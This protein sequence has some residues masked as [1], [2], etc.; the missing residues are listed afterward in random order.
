MNEL[1]KHKINRKLD[2][3]E[4]VVIKALIEKIQSL[5]NENKELWSEVN[6]LKTYIKVLIKQNKD[7]G[8]R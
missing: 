6:R 5:K 4:K 7:I 8:E 3:K 1:E 2:S